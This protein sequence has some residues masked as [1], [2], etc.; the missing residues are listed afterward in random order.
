MNHQMWQIDRETHGQRESCEF[1][2][3]QRVEE[4]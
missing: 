3:R 1:F 4:A 2:E